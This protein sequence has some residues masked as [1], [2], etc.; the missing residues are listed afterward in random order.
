MTNITITR[1]SGAWTFGT[2]GGYDFEVKHFAKASPYGIETDGEP[3]RI[4]KLWITRRGTYGTVAA[5][6]RGWY[7]LPTGDNEIEATMAIIERYN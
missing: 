6:D 7:K 4:S 5:Y 3:G 2:I 1:R